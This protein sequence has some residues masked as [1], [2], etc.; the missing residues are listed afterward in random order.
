MRTIHRG[1]GPLLLLGATLALAACDE[2][3][4]TPPPVRP[5]LSLVVQPGAATADRV[6]TGVVEPR[7]RA[8]IGFRIAGRMVSR[9]V[10]VGDPVVR[11]QPLA[12]IDPA[13]PRLAVVS[14][15]ANLASAQA[16]LTNA[17]A[18]YGRQADLLRS[19]TVAQAQVDAALAT[20]NTAQA[21][22]E[23][24]QASLQKAQ[25][26]LGYTTLASDYDGVIASWSAE[27]GQVVSI[28]QTVLTIARPDE[29]DAVVDIPDDR[30]D[31]FPQGAAFSVTLLTRDTVS[32]RGEVREIAPQSDAST[33]TRR[34][35]LTLQAP[36]DAFRLGTTV[37]I[38]LPEATDGRMEL[39]ATAVLERDGR[40]SVWLVGPDGR[41]GRR[42]VTL[43]ARRGDQ[44]PV[45]SG[46]AAGDRVVIAG[47]NSLTDGQPVKV[48]ER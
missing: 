14:A 10:N 13:I 45:T 35:R 34:V 22:V 6:F 28:G 30:V 47:V 39:P 12:A 11:G 41:A 18:A 20:R 44:V 46:L 48:T 36:P 1:A 33:R 43:G 17:T 24:A 19:A 3:A 29:R 21:R 31:R 8:Q 42:D 38:A 7:Y 26:Q 23:Q 25:E 4:D 2:K 9:A 15:R 16:Q 27:V 37:R 40:T 32:V 5:V